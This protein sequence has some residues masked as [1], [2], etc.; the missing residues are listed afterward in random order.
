L[1]LRLKSGQVLTQP[2]AAP[3]APSHCARLMT[4]HAARAASSEPERTSV[5]TTRLSHWWSQ[6]L[7]R[8]A[9]CLVNHHPPALQL[10]PPCANKTT[11]SMPYTVLRRSLWPMHECDC[12]NRLRIGSL[13]GHSGAAK[14]C[15]SSM[16]LP[17]P[18]NPHP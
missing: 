9:A 5:I 8:G 14:L 17:L 18:L 2:A 12:Q 13:K 7:Q 16:G 4:S 10:A 15:S 3:C 11:T 1:L 6:R